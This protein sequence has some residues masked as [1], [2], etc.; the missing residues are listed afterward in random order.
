MHTAP[1]IFHDI[2]FWRVREVWKATDSSYMSECPPLYPH[3]TTRL[4]L[5]LYIQ[6]HRWCNQLQQYITILNHTKLRV[7]RVSVYF[8]VLVQWPDDG[9]HSGPKCI[10][11]SPSKK[12]IYKAMCCV[13]FIKYQYIQWLPLEGFSW[14]FMLRT[15][16]KICRNNSGFG[17]NRTKMTTTWLEYLCKRRSTLKH[18]IIQQIHKYIIRRYN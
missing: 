11:Y 14:Y 13:W 10:F 4:P 7:H 1:G 16:T 2:I 15:S 5:Y 18:F 17:K 3:G 12:Y 6:H 9:P 8:L